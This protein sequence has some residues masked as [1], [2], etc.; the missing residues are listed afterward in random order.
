MPFILSQ[1]KWGEIMNSPMEVA[2]LPWGAT[3]AH[4]YHL[5][6]GTDNF[7]AEFFA[8]KAAQRAF[9]AGKK[10]VVLPG[11][12]Y[13]V[14]T[15]QLKVPLNINI[16][17][18]TQLLIVKDIVESLE[19]QGIKKLV[20]V[21]SHGGNSFVP[22]LR[23]IFPKTKMFISLINTYQCGEPKKY[24]TD[25]GDHAGE[26]ETSLMLHIYPELVAPLSTAG[27]GDVKKFRIRSF[28][29]GWCW[30]QREWEKITRDNGVGNPM[31]A[32]AE[33]GRTYAEVVINQM[34]AFFIDVA[35]AKLDD[36]Y[37]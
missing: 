29:E 16:N 32:T 8:I 2:V 36:L 24:F 20:I 30:S 37:I 10:I 21:N 23:E 13:G 17:H 34:G 19:G 33:K 26:M 9:D 31:S 4:N 18:S 22:I 28:T 5:P 6:Y 25:P 1:L 12:P 27:T 11:I 15:A 3:E 7:E 14:N 35:D